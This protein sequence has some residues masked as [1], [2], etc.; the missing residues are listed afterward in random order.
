MRL[1]E[2]GNNGSKERSPILGSEP[3]TVA[4]Q[5]LMTVSAYSALPIL[6][7]FNKAFYRLL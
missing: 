7:K 2:T 5:D 6:L 4:K 1:N 3:I